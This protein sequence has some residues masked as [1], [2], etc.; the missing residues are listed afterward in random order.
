MTNVAIAAKN[1]AAI[2]VKRA[3]LMLFVRLFFGLTIAPPSFFQRL[4]FQR[5]L[6][7]GTGAET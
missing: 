2:I 4:L 1:K 3:V 6:A 5:L 7:A